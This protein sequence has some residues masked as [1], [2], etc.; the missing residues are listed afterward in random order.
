MQIKY[1]ILLDRNG[2]VVFGK[3]REALLRAIDESE[4]LYGAAKKLNMS[5]R[6]AWGRLKASEMRL[7]IKLVATDGAGECI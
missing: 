7:G 6:A 5:Y 2:E 1:K 4:S 3:G